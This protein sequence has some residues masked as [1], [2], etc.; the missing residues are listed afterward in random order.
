MVHW[1]LSSGMGLEWRGAGYPCRDCGD[2]WQARYPEKRVGSDYTCDRKNST[3]LYQRVNSTSRSRYGEPELRGRKPW[4]ST[5]SSSIKRTA[6]VSFSKLM[7]STK[8][9]KLR[10]DWNP[11]GIHWGQR[12]KPV[13]S[14]SLIVLGNKFHYLSIVDKKTQISLKENKWLN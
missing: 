12:W 5:R 1:K 10:T 9:G 2:T 14:L 8:L 3:S 11:G 13:G 6:S 4:C 7:G